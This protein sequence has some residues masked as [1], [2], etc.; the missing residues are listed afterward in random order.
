MGIYTR[1]SDIINSNLH[2]MLDRAEDPE[3]MIRL[4][5]GEMEDTLIELRSN[6]VS[7][8]SRRKQLERDRVDLQAKAAEWQ[9]KA[10]LALGKSREDLARQ[11]LVLV[12][13][14]RGRLAEIDT[15]LESLAESLDKLDGD[16]GRLNDK[17][18][19]AIAPIDRSGHAA[20]IDQ[21]DANFTAIIRIDGARRI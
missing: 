12:E 17:L 8:I 18:R 9:A 1:L 15:E 14:Y 10:E 21:N 13:E 19:D 16:I 11:A 2:A 7:S 5:I 20:V 6:A 4:A 3:K